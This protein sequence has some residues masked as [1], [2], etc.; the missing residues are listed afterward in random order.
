MPH[1]ALHTMTRAWFAEA[2]AAPTEVQ[3]RGLSAIA[4][5]A[6]A[7]LLAP[8]GSGKTLAAF[9]HALDRLLHSVPTHSGWRV[10]YVSPLKALAYD[11]DKNLRRPLAEMTAM[12][13]HTG[14]TVRPLSIDVRTGDTSARERERQRRRPGDLL[15]TTPES[16]LLLLTGRSRASLATVEVVIIDEVHV[17]APTKRGA[18]LALSLERLTALCRAHDGREPQRV[19]LSATQ[20]PAATA[21]HFLAGSGRPVSIVD[22]TASP[23]LDLRIEMPARD[24]VTPEAVAALAGT[25]AD[26]RAP[27]SLWPAI[28]PR[29]VRA[30]TEHRSTIVFVN[31]RRLCERLVEA[32]NTLAGEALVRPHHGSM[33][34]VQRR[35]T[36][37]ALKEGRLKGIIATSSL[38]LGIDMG[39]VDLVV[40]VES[41]GSVARGLQRV[42]RAG[43]QVGGTSKGL[44]FPKFA[45]DLL[46]ATVVARAMR[47]ARLEPTHVP[48][49]PLDVLAQHLVAA[50]VVEPQPREALLALVRG[51]APYRHLPE[52]AFDRVLDMLSGRWPSDALASL[53]P[54][55]VWD[56]ATDVLTARRGAKQVLVT[57]I[58]TIPD[59]GLYR[60]TVGAGGK[61]LGE[62]DEEMVYESRAGEVF[63][64]GASAWRIVE[65]GKD[66]VVVE[67]APGEPGKMPFW[68]GD[69]VGRPLA[70]GREIGAFVA[71]LDA[72]PR[73]RAHA[74]LI[75]CD[76]LSPA[77]ADTLLEHLA[78]QRQATGTLPSDTAI[79]IE[80]FRDELGDW[81]V[82]LLTPFG[83]RVHAPWALCI[84]ALL[85]R[86]TGAEVKTITS[87]DG[88]ILRLAGAD[89]AQ[90][91]AVID[92][93]LLLPDPERV[94]ELVLEHVDRSALFAGR[95]REA[96]RRA[97]LLPKRRPDERAPLWLQRQKAQTLM[98]AA[99]Q[100]DGFPLTVE[101]ARE[102]LSDVYD[103]AGLIE[104]LTGIRAGS[105]RVDQVETPRASPWS[106]ALAAS[107]VAANLYE[108]DQPLAERR[109]QALHLDRALL[110]QLLGAGSVP[111][112]LD[113][114][115]VV[116]VE[117][118][119]QCLVPERRARHEDGLHDLL[120]R[121][122]DLTEAELAVRCTE[123][124]RPWL[125]RLQTS[126]RA[127][128]VAI[129]G[130]RRWIAIEDAAR[131]RDGLGVALPATIPASLLSPT[132][133][134][135]ESL[136]ARYARTRGPFAASEL[137]A[138]FGHDL[139]DV[140]ERLRAQGRLAC[141]TWRA[142]GVTEWC[143]LEVLRAIKRRALQAL[144]REIA[145]VDGAT[146]SR[147]LLRWHGIG[148]ERTGPDATADALVKLEG[149]TVSFRELEGGWLPARV[150]G[151]RLDWL[152]AALSAGDLVWVGDG[153]LR[154]DDVRLVFASRDRAAALFGPMPLPPADPLALRVLT[155]LESRGAMLLGE[156]ARALGD[157]T[158]GQLLDALRVLCSGGHVSNDGLSPLR[159]LMGVPTA[160]SSASRRPVL[161]AGRFWSTRSL[162][163][164][165]PSPEARA[166]VMSQTLLERYGVVAQPMAASE[167]LPGG[168][169]AV[170]RTLA[171]L[172]ESG[173]VRRGH[174]VEGLE[175]A[176]FALA[177]VVELLRVARQP[178]PLRAVVVAATDPALAFGA[179][180]PW[181][182]SVATLRRVSGAD[183]V[184]VDGVPV[185]AIDSGGTRLM[186]LVASDDP[187]LTV[188]LPSLREVATRARK[189]RLVLEQV[190][191][192]PVLQSPLAT[193]L[194][195]LGFVE[196]LHG[197]RLE[198]PPVAASRT[199]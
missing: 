173:R 113:P 117:Q 195:A 114:A 177:P 25:W 128:Q 109:A 76:Q 107:F 139:T 54:R 33:S 47:E 16:L 57:N 149:L 64:L 37:D 46:E 1:A 43:H 35:D 164:E 174:F 121:F 7:L 17:L 165:A 11:I 127:T 142:A 152:D 84:D 119:L 68:K 178:S 179:L 20:R 48:E 194:R 4:S 55:L 91:G 45:G 110:E 167:E 135:R 14:T 125:D 34:P 124:P 19:G 147:F 3:I 40:L 6:H 50:C 15:I 10:L 159:S 156:L 73:P 186:V 61:K 144:R 65:I 196:D 96:A 160:A 79:T 163:E 192:E 32:L 44:I 112:L 102:C 83:A 86:A 31:N 92:V 56:R 155:V 27:T 93:G 132:D 171:L 13:A 115:A 100:I 36:E 141:G 75:D 18:P 136:V 52:P 80:R 29:L 122:G 129:G 28:H 98:A 9:L 39:T 23:R 41:P 169:S 190:G 166:L 143:D 85:A 51:A 74:E 131:L 111:A 90:A 185:L 118:E 189:R 162:R 138:R 72:L 71:H 106:R 108:L 101:T 104:V 172:E 184:L 94:M 21:A 105:I 137:A 150:S 53:T 153:A 88:I 120:R 5:G 180:L 59:R 70:L 199:P 151:F 87:D 146:F 191:D 182:E 30:I 38:E 133:G 134:A 126:H 89:S 95:F 188:A 26:D 161:P 148:Q 62:L 69:G 145:A 183:V 140:L 63:L 66:A 198:A 24:E 99:A 12:A 82:A 103:V 158:V 168:F 181:P 187:A 123:P 2:F 154:G 170:Y 49:C 78:E 22:T 116:A 60:V 42:G 58:G 157:A 67:P 176:Q 130:E 81:R 193:R 197:L 97:L 77:A 8:T 175:G